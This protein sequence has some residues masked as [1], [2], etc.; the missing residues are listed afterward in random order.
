MVIL[1][2]QNKI[3][4]FLMI[5]AW[6]S[7]FDMF[8]TLQVTRYCRLGSIYYKLA[9]TILENSLVLFSAVGAICLCSILTVIY[10]RYF[11]TAIC[12]CSWWLIF[13][14]VVVAA[15][16]HYMILA[17]IAFYS[18]IACVFSY[19]TVTRWPPPCPMFRSGVSAIFHCV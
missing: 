17:D 16:F 12:L 4:D 8:D 13:P 5:L 2:S 19:F 10:I 6:A 18:M 9:Q 11:E 3:T 7:P 1:R 15:T 14:F